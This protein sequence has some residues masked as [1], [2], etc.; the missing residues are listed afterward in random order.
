MNCIV[1]GS[2]MK[3]IPAG[4]SRTTGKAYSAFTACPNKCKPAGQPTT[5]AAPK[6][7]WDKI[8]R[9]KVRHGLVV[10][11][12]QAGWEKKVIYAELNDYANLIMNGTTEEELGF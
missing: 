7:D 4:V 8:S 11:M 2:E 3:L 9:G 12:I 5:P 1:C 10:A 6:V